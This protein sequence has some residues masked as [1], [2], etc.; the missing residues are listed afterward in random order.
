VF[1]SVLRHSTTITYQAQKSCLAITIVLQ[2]T[3]DAINLTETDTGH[4]C[5]I[6]IP[7]IQV[8]PRCHPRIQNSTKFLITVVDETPMIVFQIQLRFVSVSKKPRHLR[9]V[10]SNET[11]DNQ[12]AIEVDYLAIDS[13]QL[14]T[15]F[16]AMVLQGTFADDLTPQTKAPAVVPASVKNVVSVT[17]RHSFE[18]W[19]YLD[20]L[21]ANPTEVESLRFSM[22]CNTEGIESVCKDQGSSVHLMKP[23]SKQSYFWMKFLL[24]DDNLN[25]HLQALQLAKAAA[26]E[27][28]IDAEVHLNA[29]MSTLYSWKQTSAN[30]FQLKAYQGFMGAGKDVWLHLMKLANARSSDKDILREFTRT[31]EFCS[32]DQTLIA[33]MCSCNLQHDHDD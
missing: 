12:P 16:A 5:T 15:A 8:T 30:S 32:I 24:D 23:Q 6:A 33:M 29:S 19:K 18:M 14:S 11:V 25:K 20:K 27:I 31:A 7:H 22:T 2:F 1:V 4:I 28:G 3:P 17:K 26:Q 13:F 21:L 9:V 10:S